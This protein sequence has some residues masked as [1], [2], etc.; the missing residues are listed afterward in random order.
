MKKKINITL[1]VLIAIAIIVLVL[2]AK[3]FSNIIQ[4]L[5]E[6][7]ESAKRNPNIDYVGGFWLSNKTTFI[8]RA[9]LMSFSALLLLGLIT[10][11]VLVNKTDIEILTKPTTEKLQAQIAS[12]KE[13]R[14]QRKIK[15][16]KAILDRES[17]KKEGDE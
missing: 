3:E 2:A 14:R 12:F 15:R 13:K 8:V 9:L 17:N 6:H 11:L 5:N 4:F 7:K 1:I 10:T 16:A